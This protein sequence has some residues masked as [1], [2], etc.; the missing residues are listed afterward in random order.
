MKGPAFLLAAIAALVGGCGRTT[1]PSATPLPSPA[2]TGTVRTS[3]VIRAEATR[4]RP[5]TISNIVN[6]KPEYQ[7]RASSVVYATSLQRGTF[8]D[9]TLLFY[10]GRQVRLTVTAPTATVNEA[11]HNVILSGGVVA[12]TPQ[13]DTLYADRMNYNAVTELLTGDGHVV[14]RDAQGNK[15]TGKHAIADLDMQQIRLFGDITA[16]SAPH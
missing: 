6:G 16:K 5:V 8:K 12:R 3:Y 13:G 2:A 4:G 1:A 14:V 15:L 9:N 10:K 11:T 7:L